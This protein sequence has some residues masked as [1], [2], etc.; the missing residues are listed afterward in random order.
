MTGIELT[1]RITLLVVFAAAAFSKGRSRAALHAFAAGLAD[2]GW[3]PA[4]LRLPTAL[5]V[6]LAELAT[7][8]L[9]LATPR[10]GAAVV[11]GLL[12]AFTVTTVAAGRAA[13]CQCF[14]SGHGPASGGTVAFLLRNSLL[15]G[16][17]LA[18][19]LLPS[20]PAAPAMWVATAGAGT[21]LAAVVVGWDELA[22]LVRPQAN[23]G[24]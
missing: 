7:A 8:P 21:A 10:A 18:A 4:R 17:A 16:A 23:A 5:G 20:H 24:A 11:L 1:S 14:G 9:L 6:V 13:S 3:L 2:I 12:A 15:A 19:G 22:Y